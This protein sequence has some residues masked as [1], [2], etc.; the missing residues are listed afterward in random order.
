MA[1]AIL[2][3]VSV[4]NV[5]VACL[6]VLAFVHLDD[7]TKQLLDTHAALERRWDE[8]HAQ[9]RAQRR[10]IDMIAATLEL[11]VHIEGA[12]QPQV[13]VDQLR[14]QVEI[15]LQVAGV[16][17]V[18]DHV[19]HLFRQVL[20]HVELLG[21]IARQRVGA[22]QVDEIEVITEERGVSL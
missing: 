15:A 11:V 14:A 20:T 2:Y 21:R 8:G 16:D 3:L 7:G 22:G 13:H 17:D 12:H 10:H 19:G 4:V 6:V 1:D 18:D 5:D 9:Q